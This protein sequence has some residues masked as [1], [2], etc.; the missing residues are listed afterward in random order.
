MNGP[1]HLRPSLQPGRRRGGFTLVEI[2][3]TVVIIAILSGMAAPMYVR[4]IE[5][6]HLDMAAGTLKNICSAQR[7]YWLSNKTFSDDLQ[8]LKSLELLDESVPAAASG[9]C[10]YTY[11]VTLADETTFEIVAT[12]VNSTVWSGGVTITEEGG[13]T[14]SISNTSGTTLN[15]TT[16]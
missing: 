16:E 10:K 4:S 9:T 7:V 11:S 13:I 2:C 6:G 5:Q 1:R 8:T 14:G 15:P 12:R 3:I